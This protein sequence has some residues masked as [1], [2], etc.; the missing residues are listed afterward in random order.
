MLGVPALHYQHVVID[1]NMIHHVDND[2]LVYLDHAK[3]TLGEN[4]LEFL[5]KSDLHRYPATAARTK[6]KNNEIENKY[7]QL[8][9]KQQFT[10]SISFKSLTA[11]CTP[12]IFCAV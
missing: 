2:I 10:A 7:K 8:G 9:C 5:H 11:A 4:V 6:E 12:G 1:L 3:Q